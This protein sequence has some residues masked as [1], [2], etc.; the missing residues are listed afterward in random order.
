M[1]K[2][3]NTIPTTELMSIPAMPGVRVFVNKNSRISIANDWFGG[4]EDSDLVEI[5]A[6]AADKVCKWILACAAELMSE[7]RAT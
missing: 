1:S 3:V 5:D 7:G 6:R 4:V 2:Q